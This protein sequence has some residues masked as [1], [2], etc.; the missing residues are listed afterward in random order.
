METFNTSTIFLNEKKG[1]K[2]FFLSTSS[3]QFD[4]YFNFFF[5]FLFYYYYCFPSDIVL[6][7]NFFVF[8]EDLLEYRLKY[9]TKY[10]FF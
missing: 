5:N 6:L 8:I 1:K 10:F 9:F 4:L 7:D 3:T 2:Y